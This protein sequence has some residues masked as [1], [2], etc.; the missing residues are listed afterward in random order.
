MKTK[1]KGFTLVELVV[2][3]AIVGILIGLTGLS[4]SSVSS[5]NARRCSESINTMI[6]K[7]RTAC[8]SSSVV[9]KLKLS[10]DSDGNVIGTFY[11]ND[12]PVNTDTIPAHGVTITYTTD[13]GATVP[14]EG[15][16]LTLYYDRSTGAQKP[17]ADNV[18]Y[19]T[20]INFTSNRTYTIALVRST[21]YHKLV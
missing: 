4:V 14:L 1:N 13:N 17:L 21:G 18:T 8:L 10:L 3:I 9:V 20:A 11:E 16:P 5:A 15:N 7:C 19:C 2:V 6:S 12:M